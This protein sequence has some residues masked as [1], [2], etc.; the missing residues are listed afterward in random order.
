[1]AKK[2]VV[3]NYTNCY[4]FTCPLQQRKNLHYD[5]LFDCQ[6]AI[7]FFGNDRHQFA[8]HAKL[9]KFDTLELD[10]RKKLTNLRRNVRIF[11]SISGR[12]DRASATEAVDTGS[13]PGRVIPKTLKIEIHSFPA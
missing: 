3:G 7:R 11:S 1:M 10:G 13:I 12:V 2:V 5:L 8:T 4:I 9:Q 6:L